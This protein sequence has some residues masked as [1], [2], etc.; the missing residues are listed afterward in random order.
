MFIKRHKA[1]FPRSRRGEYVCCA[2]NSTIAVCV[3]AS[4]AVVDNVSC[5]ELYLAEYFRF[6]TVY[7]YVCIY[8]HTYTHVFVQYIC[9]YFGRDPQRGGFQ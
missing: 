7:A 1:Y 6:H 3:L 8:I 2:L 4:A 5:R 9:T